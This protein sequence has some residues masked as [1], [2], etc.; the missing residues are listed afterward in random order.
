MVGLAT[1]LGHKLL[2][3][4]TI[5]QEV[6]FIAMENTRTCQQGY[7]EKRRRAEMELPKRIKTVIVNCP[8]EDCECW[9]NGDCIYGAYFMVAHCGEYEPKKKK[10]AR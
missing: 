6:L 2:Q 7:D 8:N 1:S 4:H 3:T 9:R 10:E 5:V